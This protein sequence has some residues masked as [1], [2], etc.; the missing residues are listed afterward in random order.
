MA[1]RRGR[2]LRNSFHV[3]PGRHSFVLRVCV[4]RELNFN[5]WNS[6]QTRR[7]GKFA[8]RFEEFGLPSRALPVN[9]R[10]ASATINL[11]DISPRPDGLSFPSRA[12]HDHR[13][14]AGAPD[15][16]AKFTCPARLIR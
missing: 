8:R 4:V 14:R 11:R 16:P 7:A 5:N 2:E 15:E 10:R 12:P 3:V 9:H 6:F 13:R 1:K